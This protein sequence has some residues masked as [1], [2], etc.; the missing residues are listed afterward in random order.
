M[1]IEDIFFLRYH[2]E[3]QYHIDKLYQEIVPQ[4]E[5][6]KGD[7]IRTNFVGFNNKNKLQTVTEF[8]NNGLPELPV[9]EECYRS[10]RPLTYPELLVRTQESISEKLKIPPETVFET[11]EEMISLLPQAKA[12][13]Q[14]RREFVT[15]TRWGEFVTLTIVRAGRVFYFK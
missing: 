13:H 12:I 1:E 6:V 4:L 15:L 2:P 8:A 7:L 14:Q 10:M 5:Y 3:R 9:P 11:M